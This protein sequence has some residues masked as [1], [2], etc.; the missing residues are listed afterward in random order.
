MIDRLLDVLTT[1]SNDAYW[2]LVRIQQ[3]R[4]HRKLTP[5]KDRMTFAQFRQAN[6]MPW[7]D[8]RA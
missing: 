8:D 2:W 4:W 6:P 3:Y 5:G 7:E 1:A